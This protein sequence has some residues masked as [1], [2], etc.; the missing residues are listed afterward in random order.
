MLCFPFFVIFFFSS[1]FL[2]SLD[3]R[4]GSNMMTF[5]MTR[6]VK[7]NPDLVSFLVFF[8]FFFLFFSFFLSIQGAAFSYLML[9]LYLLTHEKDATTELYDVHVVNL[10]ENIHIRYSDLSIARTK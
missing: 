9:S 3:P 2:C 1:V 4:A 5:G 6:L 7:I 10:P 8:F